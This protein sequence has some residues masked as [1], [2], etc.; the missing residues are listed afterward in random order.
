MLTILLP[1][2]FAYTGLRTNVGLLG[3]PELILVTVVLITIAILGKFG[4][5]MMAARTMKLPWRESAA[6]STLMNTRGLTELIVLN[7]ALDL[8]VITA[9][10]FA[11]LVVMAIVTTLMT[12]PLMRLIDPKGGS[13]RRPRRSSPRRRGS[14][15]RRPPS[16]HGRSWWRHRRTPRSMCC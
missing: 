13:A 12:G 15:S 1:L 2:Y 5:T 14:W 7:L 9:A 4:G 11:A 16:R 3:R 8:G 6:L 10:L